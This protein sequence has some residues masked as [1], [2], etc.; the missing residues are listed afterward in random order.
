MNLGGISVIITTF[1]E[2]K[3]IGRCLEP[4]RGFGDVVLVDSLS[5]DR[6]VEIAESHAVRV[7]THPY[8]SAA[9]QKNW[10]L[11]KVRNPW[12]LIL[13]ADEVLTPELKE[14]IER[15]P[16]TP[17]AQGYWIRRESEYLGRH[18]RHCGWQRDKV[19]RFFRRDRGAYEDTEVHEEI[20]LSGQVAM[21]EGRL[22][23]YPYASIEQHF[24]KINSYTTRGARDFVAKGGRLALLRMLVHPPFRFLRMYLLHRGFLDGIQGLVLCLL[25][26]YSVL[27]KYA[28]AWECSLHREER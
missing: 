26:S 14:E 10:A 17:P 25:S 22:L 11:E 21:L 27:L 6:T 1:N 19:L 13:D 4:L 3:N 18:I 12:V 9:R 23:H 5:T 7:L 2:E 16:E 15:L 20:A 24:Q 28:K 8:E